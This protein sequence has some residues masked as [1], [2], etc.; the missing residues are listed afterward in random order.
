MDWLACTYALEG[1][2]LSYHMVG[3]KYSLRYLQYDWVGHRGSVHW[4]IQVLGRSLSSVL[5]LGGSLLEFPW[6]PR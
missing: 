4:T 1:K 3:W 2:P 6:D 5:A